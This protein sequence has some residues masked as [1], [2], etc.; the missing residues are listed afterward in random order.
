MYQL[1]KTLDITLTE[2]EYQE[3]Y[4]FYAEYYGTTV[5]ELISYYGQ[6]TID[7]TIIWQKL[8]DKLI[9]DTTVIEA[10]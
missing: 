5:D 1:V 7:T 10:E 3:G 4:E 9:L 2:E 6:S 8:M